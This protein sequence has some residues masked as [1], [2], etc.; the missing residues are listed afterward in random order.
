MTSKSIHCEL[1]EFRDEDLLE[2]DLLSRRV[3]IPLPPPE[4]RGAYAAVDTEA[5]T[6]RHLKPVAPPLP[7]EHETW[8]CFGFVGFAL[9]VLLLVYFD[10]PWILGQLSAHI[11]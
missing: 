3:E 11:L 8:I 5:P 4:R 9:V 2:H 6:A 7:V 1:T 10:V